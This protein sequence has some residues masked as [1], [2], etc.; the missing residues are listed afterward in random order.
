LDTPQQSFDSNYDSKLEVDAKRNETQTKQNAID[1]PSN[2]DTRI[3]S[4]VNASIEKKPV[5]HENSKTEPE[6][7]NMYNSSD[8]DR[9]MLEP[10]YSEDEEYPLTS[11]Y[12]S[13]EHK[14]GSDSDNDA[15]PVEIAAGIESNDSDS[16]NDAI[17][18]AIAAA[19][20]ESNDSDPDINAI[21]VAI[22]A[23]GIES[24]ESNDSDPDINAIPVAIAA[25]IESDDS[26]ELV[27]SDNDS[28]NSVNSDKSHDSRKSDELGK[29]A[30][31]DDTVGKIY[32][33]DT[34]SYVI[35]PGI[36]YIFNKTTMD[37]YE[38]EVSFEDKKTRLV[39]LNEDDKENYMVDSS[40]EYVQVSYE[41]FKELYPIINSPKISESV[42]NGIKRATVN[43]L[44]D[45]EKIKLKEIEKLNNTLRYSRA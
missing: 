36:V 25:G 12:S 37:V 19:G 41:N 13:K 39:K 11:N 4:S 32:S 5:S 27:E 34:V 43:I 44:K 21:S 28:V 35:S 1:L 24:D 45:I 15:I 8:S 38:Y 23:A 22:A 20:I 40:G 30:G 17:P 3:V 18:V 42:F 2:T 7:L 29:R 6:K 9:D 26:A 14:Y 10:D 16:D 31:S 33:Y